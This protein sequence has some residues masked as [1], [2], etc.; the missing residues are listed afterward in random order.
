MLFEK[1]GSGAVISKRL[2][3]ATLY[4]FLSLFCGFVIVFALAEVKIHRMTTFVAFV[5][6]R[7]LAVDAASAVFKLDT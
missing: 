1:F 4:S 7:F 2:S 5:A 3:V 6:P